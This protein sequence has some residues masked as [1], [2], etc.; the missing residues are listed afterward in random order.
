M[1]LIFAL[2]SAPTDAV[3]G[4]GSD[5]AATLTQTA[6]GSLVVVLLIVAGLLGWL[7]VKAKN[8]HLTDKDVMREEMLRQAIQSR[9]LAAETSRVY[10]A[11]TRQAQ[12]TEQKIDRL[13]IQAADIERKMTSLADSCE[14]IER[15]SAKIDAL[16]L[17]TP[18]VNRDKYFL[19]MKGVK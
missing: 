18:G 10:E 5:A 4:A 16:A 12:N 17:A 11:L 3:V 14:Q 8:A 2:A 6:L 9:E 1:S 13:V 15:V 19:A 7:V